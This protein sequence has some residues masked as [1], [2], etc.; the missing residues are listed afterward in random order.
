MANKKDKKEKDCLE[1][2][3]YGDIVKHVTLFVTSGNFFEMFNEVTHIGNDIE[4]RF[5]GVAAPTIAVKKL[6]ISGK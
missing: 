3:E 4:D 1:K 5:I 2:T 6:M